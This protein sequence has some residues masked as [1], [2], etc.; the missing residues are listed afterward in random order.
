LTGEEIVMFTD[1]LSSPSASAS[2]SASASPETTDGV[3][4]GTTVTV[5]DVVDGDTFDIDQSVQGMDRVRL[6]GIDTPEVYGG[7]EPCGQ[8][9]S[10]FTTQRS[11]PTMASPG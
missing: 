3:S 7:E 9:A 11:T 10:D 6:I 8:E 1:A 5:V 2:A 4:G